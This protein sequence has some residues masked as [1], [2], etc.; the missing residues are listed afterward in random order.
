LAGTDAVTPQ[1][2]SQ[3]WFGSASAASNASDAVNSPT[4]RVNVTF[5]YPSIVLDNSINIINIQC[6]S[7]SLTADFNS[8]QVYN[9]A[10]TSWATAEG[11]ATSLIIITAASGC[12]SDGH[13]IYF[14]ASDFT[15][16]DKT[17]SV[18]CIGAIESVADI[19]QEVGMDFGSIQYSTSTVDS[20]PDLEATYGCATPDSTEVHG[21]PAIYCGP[22]FDERLDDKLGYYSGSDDD[23]N[24]GSPLY[25]H[26]IHRYQ[27]LSL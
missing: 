14:V 25:L 17:Q 6:A 26:C 23:F 1:E 4:V 12:S 22:D 11:N 21:L 18:S 3:L 8:T 27:S 16:S 19:A 24:V 2:I 9:A 10:K 13:Y 20:N 15:F 5:E 7:G